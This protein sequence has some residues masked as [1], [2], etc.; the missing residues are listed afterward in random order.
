ML[1]EQQHFTR[2]IPLNSTNQI[3]EHY[4]NTL[5]SG[6]SSNTNLSNECILHHK[7]NI[8]NSIETENITSTIE[9]STNFHNGSSFNSS[10][11]HL[12]NTTY[13][14]D[15]NNNFISVTNQLLSVN[16]EELAAESQILSQN[17][18]ELKE[19]IAVIFGTEKTKLK[20]EKAKLA[21]NI[22]TFKQESQMKYFQHEKHKQQYQTN[23]T[24]AQLIQ[25]NTSII[26]LNIGGTHHI[27]TTI[28]TLTT[29]PHS[30]LTK[31]FSGKFNL[32]THNG[33]V[34][35]DR[36][37]DIFTLVINYLRNK[38]LPQTFVN[39]KEKILFYEEL[40]YWLLPSNP[41]HNIVNMNSF[42]NDT[43]LTQVKSSF[44]FDKNWCAETLDLGT[45]TKIIRK[46]HELHGIVFLTPALT[47]TNPYVEFKVVINS[48]PVG[49]SS[50]FIGL[51]DKSLYKYE[52][53]MSSYW[54]DC[55]GSYYWD[56]WNTKLIK[57]DKNGQQV[58]SLIGYGCQCENR[59]TV[60]GIYY[61]S[62][63]RTIE[64]YKDYANLGVAFRD[65]PSGLTPSLDIWF[66]LGYIEIMNR[67]VPEQ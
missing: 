33:K 25:N 8:P 49:K 21:R 52:N 30:A 4:N 55:P 48:P 14:N 28:Q 23:L 35:I 15:C 26:E 53:L 13:L 24:K 32:P 16:S 18:D 22:E 65:V 46:S 62:Q 29:F 6:G 31:M 39:E 37:G 1:N 40:D 10:F 2:D 34:F 19:T 56:A 47:N 27:T 57:I 59:V 43:M 44:N 60:F 12:P 54:K 17:L 63:N 5:F 66:E 36:N 3:T 9:S 45:N 11:L 51:V 7:Q 64:F 67:I 42:N 20:S 58:G 41:L 50:L 61:N 38:Q